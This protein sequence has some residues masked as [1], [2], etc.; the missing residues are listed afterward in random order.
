MKK[1]SDRQRSSKDAQAP[2]SLSNRMSAYP[3]VSDLY[4]EAY[5]ESKQ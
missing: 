2:I 3:V 4:L 1:Q 5:W